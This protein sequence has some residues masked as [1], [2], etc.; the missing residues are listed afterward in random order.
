MMYLLEPSKQEATLSI[1]MKVEDVGPKV[2]IKFVYIGF[3]I[4]FTFYSHTL[5]NFLAPEW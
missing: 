2:G 5:I 1:A 4:R 3:F